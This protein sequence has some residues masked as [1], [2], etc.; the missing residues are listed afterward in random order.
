MAG[1]ERPQENKQQT[2]YLVSARGEVEG[3][4]ILVQTT[5]LEA[6]VYQNMALCYRVITA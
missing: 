4:A 5:A 6:G 3:M 1:F 2:P